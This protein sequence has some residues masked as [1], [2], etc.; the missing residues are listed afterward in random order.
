[1]SAQSELELVVGPLLVLICIACMYVC[2]LAILRGSCTN[3]CCFVFQSFRRLHCSGIFLF[4]QLWQGQREDEGI[5]RIYLV[6]FSSFCVKSWT[7][8]QCESTKGSWKQL[9]PQ[10]VSMSCTFISSHTLATQFMA[11]PPLS[12]EFRSWFSLNVSN[13]ISY[14]SAGVSST[15]PHLWAFTY[16]DLRERRSQLSLR[17]VNLLLLDNTYRSYL[18]QVVIVGLTEG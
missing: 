4:F 15:V 11:L 2:R 12:G 7:N 17:Y 13:A 10:C 16:F 8:A 5:C 1:M 9:I 6:H 18:S 3:E 14:R